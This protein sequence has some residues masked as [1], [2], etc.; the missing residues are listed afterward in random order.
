[1]ENEN[2]SNGPCSRNRINSI[3]QSKHFNASQ[4]ISEVTFW[5]K[6]VA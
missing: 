2:P 5:V 6:K 4:N 1:M 3:E